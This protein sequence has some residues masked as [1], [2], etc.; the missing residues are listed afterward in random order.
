M[1]DIR[2]FINQPPPATNLDATSQR[3]P[4]N[5]LQQPPPL[6]PSQP[7]PIQNTPPQRPVFSLT[8]QQQSIIQLV[9]P[10]QPIINL[11]QQPS[12]LNMTPQQQQPIIQLAQQQLQKQHGFFP[13]PQQPIFP[14]QQAN[15]NVFS[16]ILG[17]GP[18]PSNVRTQFPILPP[19]LDINQIL[20]NIVRNSAPTNQQTPFPPPF[21]IVSE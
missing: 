16:G 3:I 20:T 9:H 15:P 14:P 13:P 21:P 11:S 4:F 10:H 18:F 1:K 2:S 6:Q 8:P 5:P 17:R 12:I 7:F 19:Q